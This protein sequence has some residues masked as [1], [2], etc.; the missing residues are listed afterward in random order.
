MQLLN[1]LITLVIICTNGFAEPTVFI[2]CGSEYAKP[3][4]VSIHPCNGYYCVLERGKPTTFEITFQSFDNREAAGVEVFAIF[5]T[6]RILLRLPDSDICG[7]LNPP[8][9][10]KA[11]QIYTY[12]YTTTIDNR[13]P[14]DRQDIRWELH[15]GQFKM[16]FLCV[17]FWVRII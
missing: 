12:S 2:D 1:L 11:G 4:A 5:K 15:Y 14:L 13:F 9:P 17:Q 10:V 16:P 3:L 7:R 8:C 6:T